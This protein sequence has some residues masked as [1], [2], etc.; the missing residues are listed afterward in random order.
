M[1]M[2]TSRGHSVSFYDDRGRVIQTRS[3]NHLGGTDVERPLQN[4]V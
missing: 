4:V 3:T 2:P 1:V